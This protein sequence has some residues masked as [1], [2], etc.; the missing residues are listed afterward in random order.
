MLEKRNKLEWMV[1]KENIEWAIP[2]SFLFKFHKQI[3]SHRTR[4]SE[5]IRKLGKRTIY[6]ASWIFLLI[7]LLSKKVWGV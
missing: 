4:F 6:F 1:G 7:V 2:T 3:L 5:L